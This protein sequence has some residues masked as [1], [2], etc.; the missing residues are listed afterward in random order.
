MFCNVARSHQ[1]KVAIL[2]CPGRP[3][4]K[5]PDYGNS[6]CARIQ[7][8][9]GFSTFPGCENPGHETVLNTTFS[10]LLG[11]VFR[12]WALISSINHRFYKVFCIR[13]RA[14]IKLLFY[15]GKSRFWLLRKCHQECMIIPMLF[16]AFWVP[17]AGFAFKMIKKRQVLQC[18][19]ISF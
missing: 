5:V 12:Y 18:V 6:R 9:L 2:A 7:F 16:N 15:Q 4:L 11:G 3:D 1:R 10:I 17:F 8:S 14:L 13:F 19:F